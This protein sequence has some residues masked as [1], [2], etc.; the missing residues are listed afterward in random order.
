[1]KMAKQMYYG[2]PE[3]IQASNEVAFQSKVLKLDAETKYHVG[4]YK[5]ESA[6]TNQAGHRLQRKS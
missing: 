6:R 4:G 1:M 3:K 5:H 2:G